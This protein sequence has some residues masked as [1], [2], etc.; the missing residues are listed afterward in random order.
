MRRS[1]KRP[2][3]QHQR[4]IRRGDGF[5][6][7]RR[8]GKR[9]HSQRRAR[10]N[11]RHFRRF[12]LHH[13]AKN[14]ERARKKHRAGQRD[15]RPEV[16]PLI[17]PER[18]QNAKEIHREHR[19]YVG[20]GALFQEPAH[21]QN[22]DD[23]HAEDDDVELG[24][25]KMRDREKDKRLS[26][27]LNNPPQEMQRRPVHDQGS[28]LRVVPVL[29]DGEKNEEDRCGQELDAHDLKDGIVARE[30]FTRRVEAGEKQESRRRKQDA[31]NSR[32]NHH[33]LTCRF[34]DRLSR[35]ANFDIAHGLTVSGSR[36]FS[37]NS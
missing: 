26:K 4:K 35:L 11:G 12:A 19:P 24:Q 20:G 16:H 23:G 5:V 14:H 25:G 9:S 29:Q 6:D 3:K 10:C 15:K 13:L 18:D 36:A 37:A 8:Y 28:P 30:E 34:V 33:G 1:E 27:D 22:G 7:E 31:E 21:L 2:A 17:G 32:G